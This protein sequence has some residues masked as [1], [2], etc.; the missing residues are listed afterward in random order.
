MQCGKRIAMPI[1]I[2]PADQRHNNM[3]FVITKDVTIVN[4][5]SRSSP[6]KQQVGE[7]HQTRASFEI[8]YPFDRLTP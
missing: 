5:R 6:T 7:I 1:Y 4:M 8:S 2:Y 3:P